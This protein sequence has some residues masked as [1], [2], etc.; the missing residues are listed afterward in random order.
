[1]SDYSSESSRTGTDLVSSA[2]RSWLFCHVPGSFSQW[3][4]KGGV[5]ACDSSLV[6]DCPSVQLPAHDRGILAAGV[7]HPRVDVSCR[8]SCF[9]RIVLCTPLYAYHSLLLCPSLSATTATT[10]AASGKYPDTEITNH[11]RISIDQH[12]VN[13]P[14]CIP[15]ANP[16]CIPWANQWFVMQS[17]GEPMEFTVYPLV[18]HGP[19]QTEP[20]LCH[21]S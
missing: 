1:M 15:W 3:P 9:A 20:G 16:W 11:P 12:C 21:G 17:L 4:S 10:A 2:S 5:D 7:A 14:W 18:R 8:V 13:V 19:P 6:I